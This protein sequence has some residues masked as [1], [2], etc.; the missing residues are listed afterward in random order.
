MSD[1]AKGE[2][3]ERDK[4][5]TAGVGGGERRG[6]LTLASLD[7]PPPPPG[8]SKTGSGLAMGASSTV[9]KTHAKANATRP[10]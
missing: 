1:T 10:A 5:R 7:A 6:A 2:L 8:T 4:M 3:E 9:R